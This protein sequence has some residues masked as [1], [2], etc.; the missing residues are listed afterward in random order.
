MCVRMWSNWCFICV[1]SSTF[2][3]CSDSGHAVCH[4]GHSDSVQSGG[5]HAAAELW[6]DT[7]NFSAYTRCSWL[8]RALPWRALCPSEGPRHPYPGHGAEAWDF[9]PSA[10]VLRRRAAGQDKQHNVPP[11]H[12]QPTAHRSGPVLLRG[13]RVD[14]GPRPLVVCHDAQAVW[15]NCGESSAHRWVPDSVS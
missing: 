1:P 12:L 3:F 14:P 2:F 7:S 10:S 4:F 9:I 5:G 6:G 13:I 11:H 8:V 15:Q